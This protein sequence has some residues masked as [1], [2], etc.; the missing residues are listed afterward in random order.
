[1]IPC[2]SITV[3]HNYF[4]ADLLPAIRYCQS[5]CPDWCSKEAQK[6]EDRIL[7][8]WGIIPNHRD[9][10]LIPML[11]GDLLCNFNLITARS[12]NANRRTMPTGPLEDVNPN[13][14]NLPY[15]T[16]FWGDADEEAE[17]RE[18]KKWQASS[19]WNDGW[20]SQIGRKQEA[21][22]VGH[23][24]ASDACIPLSWQRHRNCRDNSQDMTTARSACTMV[25]IKIQQGVRLL[26]NVMHQHQQHLE[27]LQIHALNNKYLRLYDFSLCTYSFQAAR[28]VWLLSTAWF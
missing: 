18:P 5:N 6:I 26:S 11:I 21:K 16:L 12:T 27:L 7:L 23:V 8:I 19:K 22:T 13:Y 28:S 14:I 24:T 17:I 15:F 2:K 25:S 3:V 4:E 10:I 9:R 1:M 20:Q